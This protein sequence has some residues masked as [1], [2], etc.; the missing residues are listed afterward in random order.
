[1]RDLVRRARERL[2]PSAGSAVFTVLLLAMT[3]ISLISA[4]QLRRSWESQRRA[5]DLS[6]KEY[7]SL[8]ARLFGDRAYGVFEGTRLRALSSI[9]GRRV[10]ADAP[11]PTSGEFAALAGPELDLMNFAVRDENRGFF[12]IDQRS[13]RYQGLLAASTPEMSE[14]IPR[15]IKD[16]PLPLLPGNSPTGVFLIG[17]GDSVAVA[18]A[19]LRHPSGEAAGYYGFT[20]SRHMGW[21]HVGQQVLRSLPLLPA[22]LLDPNLRYGMDPAT[23]D[24]LIAIRLYNR[25][26]EVLFDSRA[27][28]ADST[29]QG[30]FT[31]QTGSSAV[32][33]VATLH[34]ALVE[35]M[36]LHLNGAGRAVLR[37]RVETAGVTGAWAVPL[38][39]MLPIAAL[40]LALAAGL[41]VWRERSLTRARRDFVASVSHELRTPLAQIRMFTETLQL[42]RERDEEE[43]GQWLN[44]VSR[45]ARVLGDL[46]ENI[47]QFSHIDADRA[48]IEK[49]RTDLGELIEEIVDGYVPLARQRSMRIL[50]D[51]PSRIF[52]L[53]DPR[54][55]RQIVVNLLDNALKYGPSG[56]T[57]IIEIERVDGV[58]RIVVS[59][60]GPGIPVSER[61]RIWRP[62]VRLGPDKGTLGGSGIGL[63]VVRNLVEQHDGTIE[64][65]DAPGGGARFTMTI[66][67]SESAA[68]LPLRATGE[69]RVRSGPSAP[70]S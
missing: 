29:V 68:G 43:R 55:M 63:A 40:L 15:N 5:S 13:G 38:D 30:E 57:V 36:R 60:Q 9:L 23:T 69:F 46:V 48:R 17:R 3:V 28:Y 12:A 70:M 53:V 32:R 35:Q 41:N 20:Y 45:E 33:A 59:D 49:E 22:A 47:L 16:F 51:A 24:S 52:A 4:V 37:T 44:I 21:H 64:V 54:A 34:P 26:N 66:E 61:R 8:G 65:D 31:F 25:G 67:I 18:Y 7:A 27:P 11:I 14:A 1:M 58:A 42:K 56:Q 39:T 2:L 62:F 50:A 6:L 10:A 19:A